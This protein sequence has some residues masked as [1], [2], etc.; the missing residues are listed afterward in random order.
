MLNQGATIGTHYK[1]VRLLGQGGMSNIYICEDSHLFGKV[2]AVKEFTAVYADPKEQATALAHFEREARLLSTLSHPNLPAINE[3]FQFQGKYYLAMEYIQGLDLSKIIEKKGG[4][5]SDQETADI[6]LQMTTV[7]YYLHCQ[8]PT[9]IIFRDVKPSNII[10][11]NG[12]VK[13]IDFGIARFFTP[14]KRGDTMRIG[15]PGYA[16]PE[17]YNGQTDPRSDIYALGMTLHQCLT[18]QDPTL[19]TNPFIVPPVLNLNPKVSPALASIVQK[20]IKLVP[21]DRY[22]SMLEMKKDLRAFL[23]AEERK[24]TVPSASAIVSQAAAPVLQKLPTISSATPPPQITAQPPSTPIIPSGPSGTSSN[25]QANSASVAQIQPNS[26]Q[27]HKG[28]TSLVSPIT[29]PSAPIQQPSANILSSP[30]IPPPTRSDSGFNQ[31]IIIPAD[32]DDLPQSP[33]SWKLG[34]FKAVFN[35]TLLA[36][37]SGLGSIY[38]GF[39]NPVLMPAR[40]VPLEARPPI[41]RLLQP[42]QENLSPNNYLAVYKYTV[43]RL[44]VA[45][46]LKERVASYPQDLAAALLKGNSDIATII[47]HQKA[48]MYD[49]SDDSSSKDKAPSDPYGLNLDDQ[50]ILKLFGPENTISAV[51]PEAIDLDK[52]DS[53]FARGL[54]AA[55]KVFQSDIAPQGQGVMINPIVSDHPLSS[56]QLVQALNKQ[57]CQASPCP[58]PGQINSQAVISLDDISSAWKDSDPSP[59]YNTVEAPSI[60]F[61]LNTTDKLPTLTQIVQATIDRKKDGQKIFVVKENK[62]AK[63]LDY[64]PQKL[65]NCQIVDS[66]SELS[67]NKNTGGAVLLTSYQAKAHP[68][69]PIQYKI[70]ILAP[71]LQAVEKLDI[72]IEWRKNGRLTIWTLLSYQ[73]PYSQASALLN[74]GFI[75]SETELDLNNL[76]TAL[77]AAD[78]FTLSAMRLRDLKG[79]F[80]GAL[81]QYNIT[82][83]TF[84]P[85][86]CQIFTAQ[87]NCFSP[88]ASPSPQRDKI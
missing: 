49:W 56:A 82:L 21:E 35:L 55:Q 79:P 20:A 88:A 48:Y 46:I 68:N 34:C 72:P 87:T 77:K 52:T 63:A 81:A 40:N 37:L 39:W 43:N 25:Q 36:C 1:V 47:S 18:G 57:I 60:Y 23:K 31:P 12:N 75:N 28:G 26:L 33:G 2:W 66:I 5:L 9:P 14:G 69:I 84:V 42:N 4:P 41:I 45:E 61:A 80:P 67:P 65:K 29:M 70:I 17:Q 54:V 62:T 58:K 22:Q 74:S 73:H 50:D 3:Y 10:I 78:A 15:S 8:K 38:F 13:L 44:K 27:A 83:Q 53:P 6:G 76:Y 16:P 59:M 32:E 86:S 51:F 11:C 30:L 7:L 24:N 71:T 64:L 85:I 19:S